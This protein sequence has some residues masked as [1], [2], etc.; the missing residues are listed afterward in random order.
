[1]TRCSS[2]GF[3]FI[4]TGGDVVWLVMIR[5]LFAAGTCLAMTIFVAFFFY[6]G[7]ETFYVVAW[8]IVVIG[9][10]IWTMS[11]ICTFVL[12]QYRGR[13]GGDA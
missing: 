5:F 12:A 10:L 6:H 9:S 13:G 11:P 1:M 8:I 7:I 4:K 2:C 3:S